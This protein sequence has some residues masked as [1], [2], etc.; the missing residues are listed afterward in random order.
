MEYIRKC[1]K[2]HCRSSYTRSRIIGGCVNR[3][4]S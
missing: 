2:T 4:N 1:S 3:R